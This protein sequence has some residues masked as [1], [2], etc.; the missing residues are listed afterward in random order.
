MIPQR[1]PFLDRLR[2]LQLLKIKL[3][4]YETPR[5]LLNSA[6]SASSCQTLR[7]CAEFCKLFAKILRRAGFHSN[8]GTLRMPS[9]RDS[10]RAASDP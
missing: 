2:L 3:K 5:F 8:S 6:N 4:F 9:E 10:A 1:L 7:N